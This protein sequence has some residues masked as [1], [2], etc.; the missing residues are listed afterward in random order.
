MAQLIPQTWYHGTFTLPQEGQQWHPFTHLGT[1]EA[2]IEVLTDRYCLDGATGQPHLASFTVPKD[3]N[4]LDVAD[5]DSPDPAVWIRRLR[6]DKRFFSSWDRAIPLY[7]QLKGNPKDRPARLAVFGTWLKGFGYDGFQYINTHEGD[8]AL[9]M[10]LAD[11]TR[12][13]PLATE[14][15]D[16]SELRRCYEGIRHKPKYRT[17]GCA[18]FPPR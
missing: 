11:L 14:V 12:L 9:S 4:L 13:R 17:W 1:R 6:S 5:F 8:G 3:L 2:A 18:G 16:L 10:A 15:V 7:R